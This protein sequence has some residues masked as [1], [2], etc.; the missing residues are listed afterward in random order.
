MQGAS[1]HAGKVYL[2]GDCYNVKPRVGV[3]REYSS[4][5]KATGRV[6]WLRD[7]DRPLLRH[8][9]GLTWHGRWGTFLGDTV[10]RKGFIY[11]LD[12][13]RALADGDLSRAVRTVVVDD[14]AVN[15]SRPEFVSLHGKDFLA[16]ADY[17]D[18]RPEV[19]LYDPEK[20]LAARRTSA[21]GVIAYRF[22]APPFNQNL[23]WD[24][25]AKQLTCVLNV[26]EGRGWRL[27]TLDLERAIADGRAWGPNVCIRTRTFPNRDELEGYR[28]FSPDVGVFVTSS[29]K[30]N[31]FVGRIKGGRP[32]QP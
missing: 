2:Y 29:R 21:S 1:F 5:F 19:R 24:N 10:A 31:L 28:R 26:I 6:I 12:W 23:D 16:T 15:G 4:D 20:L 30:S 27:E 22:L 11:Q 32:S 9:T 7:K 8:P 17:G 13:D 18:V 3:I 14:A 25:G